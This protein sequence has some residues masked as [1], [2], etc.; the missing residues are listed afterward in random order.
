MTESYIRIFSKP[1]CSYCEQ[2]KQLLNVKGLTF[3][4]FVVGEDVSREDFMSSFPNVKTVP[5]IIVGNNH[6]GGYKQLL[7]FLGEPDA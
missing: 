2:A 7:E 6:L 4:E 5:Y 3:T 1:E